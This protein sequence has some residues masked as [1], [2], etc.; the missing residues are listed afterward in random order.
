MVQHSALQ[1]HWPNENNTISKFDGFLSSFKT[2]HRTSH[3]TT[4]R[5][6]S[7]FPKPA[8]KTFLRTRRSNIDKIQWNSSTLFPSNL[9]TPNFSRDWHITVKKPWPK[10]NFYS[11]KLGCAFS[12]EERDKSKM[13]DIQVHVNGPLWSFW[14]TISTWWEPPSTPLNLFIS[15][16][17]M[18]SDASIRA[19]SKSH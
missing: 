12:E 1:L 11:I 9:F 19:Y 17:G 10:Q 14:S 3:N 7:L 8:C 15:S 2:K 18:W 6:Q 16:L 5:L 13:A 4:R